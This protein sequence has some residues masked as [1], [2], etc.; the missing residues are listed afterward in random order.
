M[1]WAALANS[2]GC[3]KKLIKKT[4]EESNRVLCEDSA[5]QIG[6]CS[7]ARALSVE[8]ICNIFVKESTYLTITHL[9]H[10]LQPICQ[11]DLFVTHTYLTCNH[12]PSSHKQHNITTQLHQHTSHHHP[13]TSDLSPSTTSHTHLAN[14]F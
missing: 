10:P 3:S 8:H 9:H 1:L 6:C 5:G 7:F 4:R 11:R 14:T 2:S 13:N 12:T